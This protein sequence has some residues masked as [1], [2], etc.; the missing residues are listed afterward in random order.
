MRTAL[1]GAEIIT[2]SVGGNDLESQIGSYVEHNCGDV[3]ADLASASEQRPA[4]SLYTGK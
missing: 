4:S 2:I 1:Q 3:R